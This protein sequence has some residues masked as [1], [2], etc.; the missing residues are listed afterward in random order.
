MGLSFMTEA[1]R[2]AVGFLDVFWLMDGV[3]EFANSGTAVT[4]SRSD[5]A[6]SVRMSG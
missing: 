6:W 2:A 5:T 3:R 4:E 1:Q